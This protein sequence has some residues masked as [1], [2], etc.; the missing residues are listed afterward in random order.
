MTH[1]KRTYLS[2]IIILSALIFNSCKKDNNTPAIDTTPPLLQAIINNAFWIPDT[3]STSIKYTA[4]TQKKVLSFEATK[5]QK[6]VNFSI[7]LSNSTNTNDFTT[8]TY[9]IDASNT[10]SMVYSTQQRNSSN[11]LVFVP[12]GTVEPGGGS[13]TITSIDAANKT[14]T[15]TFNLS[16]KVPN[17][18]VNGNLI[19]VTAANV[20]NGQFNGLSYSFT[21]N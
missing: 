3:V 8:G 4:A 20:A 10:L 12:F 14:I 5:N 15:G 1:M 19:S 16:V 6:R 13:V 21:S 17:Y 2:L 18:D 9:L 11:V 7:T